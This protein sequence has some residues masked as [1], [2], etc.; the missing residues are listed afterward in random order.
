MFDATPCYGVHNPWWV[1]RNGYTKRE[2][3][4]ISME[5]TYWM[6]LP[7]PPKP[8]IAELEQILAAAPGSMEIQPDG[9]VISV[10]GKPVHAK[11]KILTLREALGD[12]Y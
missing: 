5:G 4:P 2:S 6:A 9:S 1:P 12:T 10:E 11:P 8:S 7:D 3:D